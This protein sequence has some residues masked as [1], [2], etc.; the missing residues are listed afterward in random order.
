MP[1]S[2]I[3]IKS[4]SKRGD[5]PRYFTEKFWAKFTY[6]VIGILK[7]KPDKWIELDGLGKGRSIPIHMQ[8]VAKADL[9]KL[10]REGH[11][12]KLEE[13]GREI[14]V[15]PVAV[16]WMSDG[17]VEIAIDAVQLNRQIVRN[18]MQKPIL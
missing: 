11:E 7:S 6:S 16:T 3:T 14:F 15:S 18:T 8:R 13:V 5:E 1:N 12:E 2:T 10:T 17:S 4:I 9:E